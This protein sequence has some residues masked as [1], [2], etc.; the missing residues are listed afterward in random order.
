MLGMGLTLTKQD[1]SAVFTRPKDVLIGVVMQFIIAA[2]NWCWFS[3]GP[4]YEP[5]TCS[6]LYFSG[7]CSQ[8]NIFKCNDIFGKKVMWPCL[9]R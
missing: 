4:K 3:D 1:F 2:I 9:L 7:L 5:R 8:R 6:R